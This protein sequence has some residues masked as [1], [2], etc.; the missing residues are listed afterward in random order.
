MV[1]G[2]ILPS[3]E[4]GKDNSTNT[5]AEIEDQ[6]DAFMRKAHGKGLDDVVNDVDDNYVRDGGTWELLY[7]VSTHQI[8]I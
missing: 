6:L 8:H 1:H 2:G 3:E 7:L 4:E 5:E